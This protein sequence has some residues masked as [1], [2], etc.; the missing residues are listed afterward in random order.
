[1]SHFFVVIGCGFVFILPKPVSYAYSG[2]DCAKQLTVLPGL[3]KQATGSSFGVSFRESLWVGNIP[4]IAMKTCFV[5]VVPP[6]E[7]VNTVRTSLFGAWF[8]IKHYAV[9]VP[10]APKAQTNDLIG[11]TLPLARPVEISLSSPDGVFSYMVASG[12]KQADC[13]HDSGTL[14][15]PIDTL[16]FEQGKE[17]RTKLDRC[18]GKTKIAT[19]AEGDMMMLRALILVKGSVTEGQTVYDAPVNFTF[20]YDKQLSSAAAELKVRTGDKL[21]PVASKKTVEGV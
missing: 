15:C 16:G 14:H 20:E 6:T 12:D 11:K 4:L 7:G 17:Y 8:A 10:V 3:M 1:M 21:A 18:F 5:A 13:S 2:L 9:H 19:L